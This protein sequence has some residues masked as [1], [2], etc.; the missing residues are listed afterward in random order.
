MKIN[1]I[2]EKGESFAVISKIYLLFYYSKD[3]V[4]FNENYKFYNQYIM[5]NK[6]D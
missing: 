2:K 4:I 1:W 3:I 5:D 6:I